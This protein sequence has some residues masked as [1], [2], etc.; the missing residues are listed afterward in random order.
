VLDLFSYTGGFGLYAL[1]AGAAH[2][3]FVDGSQRAL[4]VVSQA[5]ELNGWR[6]RVALIKADIFDWIKQPSEQ[7]DA[8]SLDPPALAKS[9]DKAT[10]ALRG[11]RDLNARALAWVKPGGFLASSSCSGLISP[12]NWRAVIDE[13]AYKSRRRVRY[14]HF[15][16]QAPDHPILPAMSETEY[17]KFVLAVVD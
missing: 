11:Y 17:L 10:A 13:A 9:R 16:G 6:D 1:R 5:C 12:P 2:V 4:D 15:G 7:F 8:I 3:T 14:V